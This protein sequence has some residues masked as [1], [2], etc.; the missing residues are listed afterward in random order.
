ML[1]AF[2]TALGMVALVTTASATTA[3]AS[4][5]SGDGGV[6]IIAQASA[7]ASDAIEL[8]PYQLIT[9]PANG[10]VSCFNYGGTFKV[11]TYVYKVDWATT[12]DECFGIGPDRKIWHAWPNSGG[13]KQMPGGGYADH[14]A[15]PFLENTD[16]RSKYRR[17]AVYTQSSNTFWCQDYILPAGWDGIWY[18][19]G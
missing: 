6:S 11:G 13:W 17:L 7:Q 12:S 5:A 16:P 18:A 3:Q 10:R 19:C 14:I 1:K 2:C 9:V 15:T 8:A 4:P